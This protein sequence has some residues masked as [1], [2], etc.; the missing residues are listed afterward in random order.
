[1]Q[2]KGPYFQ[3]LCKPKGGGTYYADTQTDFWLSVNFGGMDIGS[4]K[5]RFLS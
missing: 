3:A 2:S 1:M 4:I 5:I